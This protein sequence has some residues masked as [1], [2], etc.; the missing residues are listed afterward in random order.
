MLD[1]SPGPANAADCAAALT[2]V[3]LKWPQQMRINLMTPQAPI[4]LGLLLFVLV[5]RAAHGQP[6][7]NDPDVVL[8]LERSW[9]EALLRRDTP[10][11][12]RIL[13]DDLTQI[14]LAGETAGKAAFLKFLRLGDWKYLL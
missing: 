4:S 13:A 7:V 10:F 14:G 6:P 5:A 3:A 9:L 12:E 8:S 2:G 11:F 1:L